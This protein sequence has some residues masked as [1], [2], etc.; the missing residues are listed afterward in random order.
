VLFLFSLFL[1]AVGV[2][3]SQ[4]ADS[5][6]VAHWRFDEKSWDAVSDSS[7]NRNDGRLLGAARRKASSAAQSYASRMPWSKCRIANPKTISRTGLTVSAWIKRLPGAKWSMILSRE[8]QEGPS[9]Y[10]GLAVF[11]NKAL[12]SVDRD[13]A[14]Y[15]N[16]K[17]ALPSRWSAS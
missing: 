6:L 8:I 15:K 13:R 12:F 16:V 9:E 1:L 10:F 2:S 11:Q 7:T 14:H 5:G 3:Q 17:S 4:A